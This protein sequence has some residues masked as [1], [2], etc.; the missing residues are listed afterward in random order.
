LMMTTITST[1]IEKKEKEKCSE[2]CEMA[3]KF[4]RANIFRGQH[5]L[6]VKS[7]AVN[8]EFAWPARNVRSDIP[9]E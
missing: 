4:W 7:S 2:L 3:R 8:I 9:D 5:L 6:G 1:K